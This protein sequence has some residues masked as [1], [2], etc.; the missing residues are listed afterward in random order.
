MESLKNEKQVNGE[1]QLKVI[2]TA[3][4]SGIGL[5]VAQQFLSQGDQV[6]VCDVNQETLSQ[7]LSE[8]GGL[9]GAIA[10]VGN[11]EQ[12]EAFFA[13]A[14]ESMGGVDV[15]LT[16]PALAAQEMQ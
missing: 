4:A 9:Q 1:R 13:K 16:M 7:V 2:V 5:A 11:P 8:N 3:G 14:L 6:W 10:D 15:Q 12:V